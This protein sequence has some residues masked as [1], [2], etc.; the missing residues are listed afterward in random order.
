MEGERDRGRKTL[1]YQRNIDHLPP[2]HPQLE[3]WPTVQACAL[4]RNQTSYPSVHGT[5]STPLSHTSQGNFYILDLTEDKLEEQ[6]V[7]T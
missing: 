7:L 2:T 4:M 5:M 3:S 1:M 6:A